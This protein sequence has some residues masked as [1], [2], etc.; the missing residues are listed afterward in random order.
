MSKI[1]KKCGKENEANA[2]FCNNCGAELNDE[3][4]DKLEVSNTQKKS[5]KKMIIFFS[6]LILILLIGIPIFA[7]D[8]YTCGDMSILDKMDSIEKLAQDG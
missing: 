6:I 7:L 8:S 4:K 5:N 1:C 2:K 3:T